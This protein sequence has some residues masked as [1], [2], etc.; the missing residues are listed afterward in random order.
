M[1]TQ[2]R[3]R[4]LIAGAIAVVSLLAAPATWADDDSDSDSDKEIPFDEAEVFFELNDT[5]GD[6]GIHSLID[7]GPWKK[8]EIEDPHER[9]M[10]RVKARGRLRRQGLTEL[11]FESAEPRFAELP[12]VEFFARFPEGE[13]E[14]E[15]VTLDGDELESVT[16]V[17]HLMPAPAHATVNGEMLAVVCDDE[18][19]LYD[20]PVV[21]LPIT[22]SW[23]A[24]TM[25]HPD[26]GT[27]PPEEI[28]VHNYQVVVEAEIETA[29]GEELE[30]ITSTILPPA[31][32]SYVVPDAFIGLS[33]VW[34]YEVLVR[35]E[36]FNQTAVESC[37][38]IA[39]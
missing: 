25:S 14:I 19:P 23:P 11:F 12:P 21:T 3:P 36:S 2:L 20:A 34:K 6:L 15:G 31:D 33:D 18:D 16:K 10:L 17:T 38:V 27:L 5:D 35:E 7:G 13:Y 4:F 22:I 29:M 32:T 24:V 39:E 8:L 30:V 26:L 28:T 9:R 1:D 37:F